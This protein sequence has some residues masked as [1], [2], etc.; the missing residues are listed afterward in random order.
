MAWALLL[1]NVFVA[2]LAARLR[3]A[4]HG[5]AYASPAPMDPQVWWWVI[6]GTGLAAVVVGVWG[7]KALR[8]A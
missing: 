2:L 7:G 8:E 5:L 4:D 1:T 3:C 6:A